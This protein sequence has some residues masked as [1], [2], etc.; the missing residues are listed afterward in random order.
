M[1]TLSASD[2]A[3]R[4]I[5]EA[6]QKH[7][8]TVKDLAAAC[9]KAGAGH[10]TAAVITNLETRR[11]PGR[12]VTLDEI[13][14]L[15]SVLGVPPLQLMTPLDG[16][17]TLTALPGDAR[18]PLEA[19]A[20]LSDDAAAAVPVWYSPGQ[21]TAAGPVT[22]LRQI[23][24]VTRE[25]ELRDAGLTGRDPA[26]AGS[27]TRH[28]NT[29]AMLGLRLTHL[30]AALAAQRYSPPALDAT[31]AILARHGLPGTF[32]DFTQGSDFGAGW[33]D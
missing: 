12:H 15:A 30:I 7:G 32:E 8:W 3:A 29:I 14:A 11:R 2:V 31:M 1:T 25:I 33:E 17:E 19:A 22:I 13:L 21:D 10:I 20:W 4:R 26:I 23:R 18:N 5:R 28:K 6:R 16:S 27:R 9:G 24:S